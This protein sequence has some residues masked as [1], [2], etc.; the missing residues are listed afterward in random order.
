M[1][2][3]NL[4]DAQDKPNN[5]RIQLYLYDLH[6]FMVRFIYTKLNST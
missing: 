5:F 6:R 1:V 2:D 3:K 4:F